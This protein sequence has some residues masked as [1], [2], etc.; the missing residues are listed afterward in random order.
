MGFLSQ[1][2]A[3]FKKNLILWYRNLFGSIGEILFP[4]VLMFAVV[5]IRKVVSNQYFDT[6]SYLGPTGLGYY[7]NETVQASASTYNDSSFLNMGFYP[8]SP[9]SLCLMYNRPLIAF[10]GTSKLYPGL[11]NALFGSNGG[12]I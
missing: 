9:F 7:Y 6:Q 8:G 2:K 3:L 10:V 1:F 4:V 5:I 11:Q 12:N